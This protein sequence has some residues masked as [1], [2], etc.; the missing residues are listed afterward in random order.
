MYHRVWWCITS[1]SCFF[2]HV[3]SIVN[4]EFHLI[5]ADFRRQG[6]WSDELDRASVRVPVYLWGCQWT[7]V[8]LW[9]VCTSYKGSSKLWMTWMLVC[10]LWLKSVLLCLILDIYFYLDLWQMHIKDDNCWIFQ[11]VFCWSERG[12]PARVFLHDSHQEIHAPPRHVVHCKFSGVYTKLIF[13]Y[14][15]DHLEKE[16][17]TGRTQFML[18]LIY[19]K[20]IE[21]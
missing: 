5:C 11:I 1:P 17:L 21:K 14:I 8:H 18:L 15:F 20:F 6:V 10:L 4:K 3:C 12:A 19:W 7:T 13:P 2:G 16:R 9:E